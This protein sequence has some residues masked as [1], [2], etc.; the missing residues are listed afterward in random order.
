MTG[1][2]IDLSEYENQQQQR[3]IKLK[4]KDK[5]YQRSPRIL[6]PIFNLSIN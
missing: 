5:N 4:A 3:E 2:A 1:G 6:R